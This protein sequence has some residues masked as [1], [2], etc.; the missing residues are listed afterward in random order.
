MSSLI[1]NELGSTNF[2]RWSPSPA[3]VPAPQ[4]IDPEIAARDHAIKTLERRISDMERAHAEAIKRARTEARDAALKEAARDEAQALALLEANAKA[5]N[6]LF[7]K[8]LADL[9]RLAPLLCE[10]AL[11]SVFEAP[12][13]YRALVEAALEL[14]FKRLTR[15]SVVKV[16]VSAVDFSDEAHLKALADRHPQVAIGADPALGSGVC[17]ITLNMGGVELDIPAHWAALKETLHAMADAP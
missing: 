13:Q 1:R 15:E 17:H 14:Q 5:A 12:D 11:A 16:T 6:A 7:S 2:A 3:S 9:E 8:S 4:P 10:T